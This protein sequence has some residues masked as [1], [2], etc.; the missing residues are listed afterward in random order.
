MD[1]RRI[2]LA[3][4]AAWVLSI[5]LGYL[6]NDIWLARLYEANAWAFR[7][8]EDTSRLLPLGLGVQLLAFFAFA[9]AYAKGHE[10]GGSPIGEGT[11]FGVVVAIMIDGFA[12][13]WNYVTEPIALR[14]GALQ[15][16]EHI[17]E[18]GVY[19]AIVGLIY[20]PRE[21]QIPDPG[22]QIPDPESR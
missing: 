21:F 8:R 9:F 22:S 18:F 19:G 3:A 6:I 1:Y 16:I 14:L 15:M 13:V 7:H 17:G 2:A 12:I 11:R 4:V 20:R 10:G 5:G